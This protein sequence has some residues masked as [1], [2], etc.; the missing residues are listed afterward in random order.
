MNETNK[1]AMDQEIDLRKLAVFTWNKK[2]FVML[3][4][5]AFVSLSILYSLFLPNFYTSTTLLIPTE[6]D[7]SLSAKLSSYS[8]LAR[9]SG[10]DIGSGSS[11]KSNEAIQ[12]IKSFEFFSN[13]FLPNV[14]LENIIA[15]KT[16]DAK[17]NEVT[18]KK[19]IFDS[20]TKKW[21][22]KVSYPKKIIPS[23]QEAY[24]AF[25]KLISISQDKKN[26]FVTISLQ[27]QSPII[28]KKWLDLI[29]KNI[30]GSMQIE[31]IKLAEAYISFLND[32][33]KSNNI[34]SLKEASSQLL[35]DQMQTLMLASAN[36]AY[37]FKIIDSPIIAEEKSSPNRV[38]IVIL[39]AFLGG[40][41]SI[42]IIFLQYFRNFLK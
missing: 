40:F 24:K 29:I 39:G 41:V 23:E 14:K 30:N 26:Q 8:S 37:I 2:F 22:R 21:V 28:A 25:S 11:S 13:H 18:Y 32:S 16:W 9:I 20:Q 5:F 33:Q 19:S 6:N 34:Q 17:S 38:L 36:N 42:L 35:E 1:T 3:F 31:D 10:I 7:E 27:H 15:V 12:R 4:T